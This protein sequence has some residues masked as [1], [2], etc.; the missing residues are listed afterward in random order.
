M[1]YIYNI[2]IYIYIYIF[3]L[4]I[5]IA[6]EIYRFTHYVPRSK[7]EEIGYFWGLSFFSYHFQKGNYVYI[8]IQVFC[9]YFFRILSCV[10]VENHEGCHE[11]HA[12]WPWMLSDSSPCRPDWGGTY[13]CGDGRSVYLWALAG[14][15][16]HW[17][18]WL[19][20][21]FRGALT[22]LFLK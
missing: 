4:M 10:R 6:I 17:I 16:G 2:Y 3:F 18:L 14:S 5:Q 22:N 15:V 20:I 11:L 12:T 9:Q 1:L 8:Y 21:F 19:G 7:P 13:P